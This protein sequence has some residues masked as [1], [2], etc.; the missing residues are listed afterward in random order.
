MIG[1]PLPRRYAALWGKPYPI[2]SV[3]HHNVFSFAFSPKDSL[4]ASGSYDEAGFLWDGRSARLMRLLL[5]HSDPVGSVDFAHGGT[6]VVNCSSVGLIRIRD[7]VTSQCLRTL[8]HE[9]CAA[10][11]S[12]RFGKYVLALTLDSSVRL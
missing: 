1:H 3:G 12:V 8:V 11:V 4:L 2:P 5:A 9:D 6:L 7:T 10:V